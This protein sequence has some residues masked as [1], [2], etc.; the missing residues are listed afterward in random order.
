MLEQTQQQFREFLHEVRVA[1]GSS[2]SEVGRS[3]FGCESARLSADP[4]RHSLF[5]NQEH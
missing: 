4:H 1:E 3:F 5:G 2:V